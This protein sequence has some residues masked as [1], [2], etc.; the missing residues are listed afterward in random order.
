ML[1]ATATGKG[2]H[3]FSTC[4]GSSSIE[5]LLGSSSDSPEGE[6]KFELS[7]KKYQTNI[8]CLEALDGKKCYILHKAVTNIDLY[9]LYITLMVSLLLSW[10]RE[11]QQ[12]W[13]HSFF[14]PPQQKME[15]LWM[16]CDVQCSFLGA[17]LVVT[18]PMSPNLRYC[19]FWSL[20]INL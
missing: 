20:N 16:H 17:S 13:Q 19:G 11:C 4:F 5:L 6:F 2:E 3:P 1:H 14:P 10:Q 15:A 9:M 12:A 7:P 18:I 8:L